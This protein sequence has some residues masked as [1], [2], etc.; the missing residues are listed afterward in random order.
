MKCFPC[1]SVSIVNTSKTFSHFH[2]KKTLKTLFSE[3][4]LLDNSLMDMMNLIPCFLNH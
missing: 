2:E 4:F 3:V 1:Y